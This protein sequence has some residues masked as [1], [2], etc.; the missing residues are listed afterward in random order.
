MA[1]TTKAKKTKPPKP[2]AR[3]DNPVNVEYEKKAKELV[4]YAMSQRSADWEA[5]ANNLNAL[6]VEITP[7]GLEN[8]IS[9]GG[10]S[11]AFALQCMEALEINLAALPR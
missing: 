11:A 3:K 7:R 1:T 5:L 6:G 2:S 9:R 10:F 4:K 8:K